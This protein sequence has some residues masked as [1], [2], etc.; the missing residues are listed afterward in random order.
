MVCNEHWCSDP[1]LLS[2]DRPEY[3]VPDIRKMFLE[4]EGLKFMESGAHE[5][6]RNLKLYLRKSAEKT[7]IAAEI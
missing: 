6:D 2:A 1:E 5:D 4:Y 7:I 3:C